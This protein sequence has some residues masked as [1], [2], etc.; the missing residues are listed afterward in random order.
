MVHSLLWKDEKSEEDKSRGHGRMKKQDK[1]REHGRMKTG[2]SVMQL[3]AY[4]SRQA[5]KKQESSSGG[6]STFYHATLPK[7][8]GSQVGSANSALTTKRQESQGPYVPCVLIRRLPVTPSSD[9]LC[10]V[11]PLRSC[12][13]ITPFPLPALCPHPA[14]VQWRHQFTAHHKGCSL[15][16]PF[17]LSPC[18][19]DIS[20]LLTNGP[21]MFLVPP[22]CSY[23]LTRPVAPS[24]Q[25]E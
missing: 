7:V 23:S 6:S 1:S 8:P 10:F 16:F 5:C 19:G 24:A 3:S 17:P 25:A 14:F 15:F 20:S 2:S 22:S 13:L 4:S 9:D 12:S 18:P 11:L 21:M